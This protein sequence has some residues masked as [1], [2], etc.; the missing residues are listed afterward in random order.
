MNPSYIHRKDAKYGATQESAHFNIVMPAVPKPASRVFYGFRLE[1]C[2]NDDLDVGHSIVL[3][4]TENAKSK[5]YGSFLCV[6]CASAV[7]FLCL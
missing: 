5:L 1:D 4:C 2:R 7:R 6:L 3:A